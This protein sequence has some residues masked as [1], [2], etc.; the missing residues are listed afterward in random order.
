MQSW[1]TLNGLWVHKPGTSPFAHQTQS[2]PVFHAKHTA[3]K[4]GSLDE[5]PEQ[6]A[7]V[8]H[9][10]QRFF[11]PTSA[12]AKKGIKTRPPTGKI[13]NQGVVGHCPTV[14]SGKARTRLMKN[15]RESLTQA[16]FAVRKGDVDMLVEISWLDYKHVDKIQA[17][18]WN[19][20]YAAYRSLL[21][22]AFGNWG[23]FCRKVCSGKVHANNAAPVIYCIRELSS[24]K[25]SKS[26]NHLLWGLM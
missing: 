18:C 7:L 10:S 6:Q 26:E 8:P 19:M 14:L 15:L 5:L 4:R 3:H 16:P 20:G 17:K 22:T 25:I 23:W 24:G 9:N 12:K 2:L 13:K 1:F 21:F 11:Q